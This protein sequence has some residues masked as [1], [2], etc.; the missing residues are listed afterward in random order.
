MTGVSAFLFYGLAAIAC[1][2]AA[3]VVLRRGATKR[4]DRDATA[5]ALALSAIWCTTVA[6]LG[7]DVPLTHLVEIARNIAWVYALFRHFANDG[8]DETLRIVRPVVLTLGMVEGLQL[9][10]LL[11]VPA[12]LA[13]EV[14]ALL[15]MLVAVGALVLVHNLFLG[16]ASNSRRLLAWNSGGQALFWAFELNL[17]TVSYLTGDAVA[18]LEILRALVMAALAASFVIGTQGRAGLSFRPSRAVTFSSLSLAVLAVY[19]LA[20][21]GLANGVARLSGDLARITQV[22]FLL[23]AATVSLVWLPSQ[24]LRGLVRVLVLKH[25]FKHRYDYREEWLRFTR[26]IASAAGPGAGLHERAVQSLADIAD[27]PAGLLLTPRD[28]GDLALAA[29]WRWPTLEVPPSAMPAALAR[30]L[31]RRA[32]IIDFDEV[33]AGIDHVGE[34]LLVPAWLRDEERAWA[35][36]PLLHGE[37]LVGVV[38]L[39]RPHVA[40]GLDWEDFDLL[41]IAG[42]QVASY[43]A[44]QSGQ[45]ALADA[46]RFDQFNRR[47]A[48]VM[49]DIKNLSS[50]FGLLA[51]NAERHAENPA[52]RADMLVTLR[53][54]ADKLDALVSRLGRYGR[55]NGES[56]APLDLGDLAHRLAKRYGASRRI[57]CIGEGTCEVLATAEPLEQALGHLVQ[58]AIEASPAEAPIVIEVR[59]AALRG[60]IA[61]IDAGKGMSAQ[62]LRHDLF[63]P[64]V[65]TKEDGFGIGACEARE[66]IRGMGGRLDVESREG[67]GSRF[68]VSLPL[69]EA[70][71]LLARRAAL[72][73]NHF[74]GEAA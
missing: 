20:M 22:G 8:R 42:Q 70:S 19:F 14:S 61:V 39:A 29:R 21:V 63:R 55:V 67:L 16:A 49:H 46:E 34:A 12:G 64:F 54:S 60:E 33:R 57:D 6:A 31:E 27:S 62:F 38:V 40:R 59:N 47:M 66:L 25:L 18:G 37:R 36:V 74:D 45:D 17:F 56:V 58:N 52:F 1:A 43:L 15:R 71:R 69:A 73:D 24:R 11:L 10:L 30:L 13:L 41:G 5:T 28:D 51:R 23:V 35:S 9:I 7:V 32:V 50:Q 44:E 72:H 4:L 2:I 26:T 3:L 68:V 53:N 65:S 48:F